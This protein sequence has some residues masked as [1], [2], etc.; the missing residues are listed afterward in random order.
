MLLK[1]ARQGRA[2]RFAPRRGQSSAWLAF[3]RAPTFAC[4]CRDN[5]R[6][7]RSSLVAAVGDKPVSCCRRQRS[8]RVWLPARCRDKLRFKLRVYPTT[9]CKPASK[10]KE[11]GDMRSREQTQQNVRRKQI[12]AQTAVH[13]SLRV[14]DAGALRVFC[15]TQA[16]AAHAVKSDSRRDVM[17][18]DFTHKNFACEISLDHFIIPTRS[19]TILTCISPKPNHSFKPWPNRK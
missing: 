1:D 17:V 13:A 7:L 6:T 19:T 9:C 4:T 11:Q 8:A 14:D 16:L 18:A 12:R 5:C 3:V 15:A 10:R 2:Q